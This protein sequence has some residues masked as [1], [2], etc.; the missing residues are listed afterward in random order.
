M[1]LFI[2]CVAF[3]L[4]AFLLLRPVGTPAAQQ[5]DP[6]L[7][8]Y[9]TQ[10]N[11][12]TTGGPIVPLAED[13]ISPPSIHP[14]TT[15][16]AST[17]LVVPIYFVPHDRVPDLRFIDLIENRMRWVQAWYGWQ[18][19]D[20]TFTLSNV[21]TVLGNHNLDWY[22]ES[23][24]EV[25]H[26]WSMNVWTN[27][28]AEL[29]GRG[30]AWSNSRI[31]GMFFDHAGRGT[32]ALGGGW[33][34]GGGKFIFP[35]D[36]L[37]DDC[38]GVECRS[39]VDDGGI[40]HELGHA[41]GLGHIQSEPS[42][43][44]SV[45]GMGFYE[46]PQIGLLNTAINPERDILRT[47]PMLNQPL[48]LNNPSFEDCLG[49]WAVGGAVT[50]SCVTDRHAGLSAL[51]LPPSA[52]PYLVSQRLRLDQ[53]AGSQPT[54]DINLRV[55]IGGGVMLYSQ[56]N[57]AGVAETIIGNDPMLGDNPI[58][59]DTAMSIRVQPG[60]SA[61]LWVNPYYQEPAETFYADDPDL[62]DN[63]VGAARTSSIQVNYADHTWPQSMDLDIRVEFFNANDHLIGAESINLADSYGRGWVHVGRSIHPLVGSI[64]AQIVID[65]QHFGP[66]DGMLIDDILFDLASAAPSQPYQI[67]E[68][69]P[70]PYAT[71]QPTLAWR[72]LVQAVDYQIQVDD[73]STFASPQ[74]DAV[75]QSPI[76]ILPSA[77]AWNQMYYWRV[78]ARN[79]SGASAWLNAGR[80]IAQSGVGYRSDE[81]ESRTLDPDW[82][83]VREGNWT[84]G[85][86]NSKGYTGEMVLF[87]G[88]GTLY[89]A[90]GDAKGTLLRQVPGA[91]IAATTHMRYWMTGP[92]S[93]SEQ[94]GMIVYQ[95]DENF[96][97]LANTIDGNGIIGLAVEQDGHPLWYP[98]MANQHM[99]Y[100]RIERRGATYR[101]LFSSDGLKWEQVG[102]DVIANWSQAKIGLFSWSG[103]SS[104]EVE[105]HFEFFRVTDLDLQETSTPTATSTMTITPTTTATATSTPT[106]TATP[107]ATATATPK[108]G[109]Q[110]QHGN[111]LPLVVR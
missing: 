39:S 40:A 57:Y 46:F 13:I 71:N 47:N 98:T 26:D 61:V 9:S 27:L 10:S 110:G 90:G 23:H 102:P 72:D 65:V 51:W 53:S 1:H 111:Y 44:E 107:T 66:F 89:G 43:L 73:D 70:M 38:A 86:P 55:N 69:D 60:R 28:S 83:W 106:P 100:M 59:Q 76:Y 74:F 24:D 15:A 52:A 19:G 64:W 58:G 25:V 12:H 50:P 84:W 105:T 68:T 41:L 104:N 14:E 101:G 75:T 30:Y 21:V 29:D 34:T 3:A 56:P 88:P 2:R 77:I 82:A 33:A 17:Y 103:E 31:Y 5:N 8:L 85:G 63:P 109:T 37:V 54:Y 18:I 32:P 97:T 79:G 93:G 87:S 91:A 16:V 11:T 67:Y 49:F 42:L 7:H 36:R 108:S 20:R 4:V 62:S 45:M 78:R 80:L 81:F 96:I 48:R 6:P 99:Y 95:D 92:R 22:Y 35:A 94:T